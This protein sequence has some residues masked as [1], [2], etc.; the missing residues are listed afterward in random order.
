MLKYLYLNTNNTAIQKITEQRVINE[1]YI[2]KF[3][4]RSYINETQDILVLDN[5][6]KLFLI[7]KSSI[8]K[9]LLFFKGKSIVG[10]VLQIKEFIYSR[11]NYFKI[12]FFIGNVAYNNY[13]SYLKLSFI[14]K[15]TIKT[16]INEISPLLVITRGNFSYIYNGLRGF[17]PKKNF[18]KLRKIFKQLRVFLSLKQKFLLLVKRYKK[19]LLKS[20]LLKNLKSNKLFIVKPKYKNQIKNKNYLLKLSPFIKNRK[21]F[22]KNKK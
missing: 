21:R 18:G 11:Q 8:E 9:Y 19:L 3:Y 4:S 17:L 12:K 15:K 13:L 2:N 20:L 16:N 22:I 10:K 6:Y 7:N 1:C 5:N 14:L